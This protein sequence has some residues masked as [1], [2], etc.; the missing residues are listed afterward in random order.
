MALDPRT[1]D[2]PLVVAAGEPLVAATPRHARA[3]A[4]ISSARLFLSFPC[5]PENAR[6]VSRAWGERSRE[7]ARL[8]ARRSEVCPRVRR[9]QVSSEASARD[10]TRH[11]RKRTRRRRSNFEDKV[12]SKETKKAYG[13]RRIAY[14]VVR[15]IDF[16]RATK[17]YSTAAPRA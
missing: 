4:D 6:R 14:Y 13:V 2:P 1:S 11:S 16:S 9:R 17:N 10:R 15:P 8:H 3:H 12:T 5:L 7:G